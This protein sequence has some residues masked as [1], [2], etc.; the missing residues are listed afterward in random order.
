MRMSC[1][2][3]SSDSAVTRRASTRRKHIREHT[4][5]LTLRKNYIENCQPGIK[6]DKSMKNE[7]ILEKG[8]NLYLL[9][10]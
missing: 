10:E 6:L 1:S 4:Y 3:V 2:D 8:V 9:I 7:L 5:N